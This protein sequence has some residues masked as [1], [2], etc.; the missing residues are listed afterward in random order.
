MNTIKIEKR[1]KRPLLE[2]MV[3]GSITKNLIGWSGLKVLMFWMME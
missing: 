1:L 2:M 3:I